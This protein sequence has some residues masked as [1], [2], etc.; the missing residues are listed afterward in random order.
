MIENTWKKCGQPYQDAL[1]SMAYKILNRGR[2]P[3]ENIDTEA[4]KVIVVGFFQCHALSLRGYVWWNDAMS[5]CSGYIS[6]ECGKGL[7]GR[8]QLFALLWAPG[9]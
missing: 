6:K 5:P 8:H 4:T 1:G 7:L 9:S 2:L 3:L